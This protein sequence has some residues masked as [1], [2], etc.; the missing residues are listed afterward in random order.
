MKKKLFRII[1]L[2]L[3]TFLARGGWTADEC[4]C[5]DDSN[6]FKQGHGASKEHMSG[7]YNNPAR[8]DVKCSWDY[9]LGASFIYWQPRLTGLEFIKQIHTV[10]SPYDQSF[11]MRDMDFDYKPGFKIFTGA[12][13]E[14]DDWS[15]DFEYTR[16]CATNKHR[17]EIAY[18]TTDEDSM[19]ATWLYYDETTGPSSDI[20]YG[21]ARWKF[22]YNM[23]DLS[24]ARAH[25]IGRKFTAKPFIGMRGGWIGNKYRVYYREYYTAEHYTARNMKAK[26][27]SWLIG[28]RGGINTMWHLGEGFHIIGNAAGSILYQKFHKVNWRTTVPGGQYEYPNEYIYRASKDKAYFTPN[29]EASLGLGWGDYFND[30]NWH[31][32]VSAEY[33]FHYFW[34]QNMMRRLIDQVNYRHDPSIGDLVLHGLVINLSFD[35]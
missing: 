22:N 2:L 11:R 23:L 25:Y 1:P 15:L 20:Y 19:I 35:F 27:K 21:S 17:A 9:Y 13:F 10:A 12:N 26:S 28:P 8:I 7:S 14:R 6:V 18:D 31:V 4:G 30:N 33:E 5:P 24:L 16:L 3:A 32:A 29:I 34:N